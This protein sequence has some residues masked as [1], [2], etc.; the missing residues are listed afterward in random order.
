LG[1][2]SFTLSDYII[3]ICKCITDSQTP[4]ESTMQIINT[5]QVYLANFLPNPVQSSPQSFILTRH[6]NTP[7][8]RIMQ[9]YFLAS[10][11][12]TSLFLNVA[13]SRPL[14]LCLL[15]ALGPLHPSHVSHLSHL[16]P[17]NLSSHSFSAFLD[18][19]D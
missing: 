15:R 19:G 2:L 13:N 9:L 6:L 4:Q 16:K 3:T 1:R 7:R 10:T 17:W 8:L 14:H 5:H 11:S 12:S 18:E